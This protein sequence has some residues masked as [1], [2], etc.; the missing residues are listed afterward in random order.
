MDIRLF[1]TVISKNLYF[2]N[3]SHF[4]QYDGKTFLNAFLTNV[5]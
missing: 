5:F 1:V 2:T 4:L 3:G